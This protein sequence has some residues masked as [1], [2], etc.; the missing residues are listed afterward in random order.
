MRYRNSMLGDNVC[1]N[2][3]CKSLLIFLNGKNYV[4]NI[5]LKL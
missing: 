2:F 1:K 5:T 3:D 4:A